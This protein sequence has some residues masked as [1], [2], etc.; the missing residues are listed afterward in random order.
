LLDVMLSAFP[1]AFLTALGSLR[2][3]NVEFDRS[4]PRLAPIH[5]ETTWSREGDVER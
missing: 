5:G 3:Y 4:E 2:I 1:G